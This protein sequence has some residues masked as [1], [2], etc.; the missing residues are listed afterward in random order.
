[1]DKIKALFADKKTRTICIIALVVILVVIIALVAFISTGYKR[2]IKSLVKASVDEEKL[3][4]FVKNKMDLRTIYALQKADYEDSKVKLDS[5]KEEYKEAEKD[6]YKSD[7]FIEDIVDSYKGMGGDE[8]T[9]VTIKKIGSLKKVSKD[10]GRFNLKGM[11]K[12]KFTLQNKEDKDEKIDCYAYFWKG[13][14][15]GIRIDYSSALKGLTNGS[16]SSSEVNEAIDALKSL[17]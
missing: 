14:I 7:E 2:Q 13:K 1:M 12:A 9:K 16:S 15:V 4:K 3:E 5:F 17:Y 6:D 10:D 11:K 8:D